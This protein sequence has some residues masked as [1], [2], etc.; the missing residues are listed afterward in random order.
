MFTKKIGSICSFVILVALF[1]GAVNFTG[2]VY[3][4]DQTSIRLDPSYVA[5][6]VGSIT[7]LLI[8][9]TGGNNLTAYDLSLSYD[10]TILQLQSWTNGSYFSNLA[11]IKSE[12]QPGMLRI[13][14]AQVGSPAVSGDG[15]IL[16]LVF[17]GNGAGLSAINIEKMDLVNAE[18]Q[19]INADLS[20]G[21]IEVYTP[22]TATLEP[23]PTSPST[24]TIQPTKTSTP[25]KTSTSTHVFSATV[26]GTFTPTR[27][28]APLILQSTSTQTQILLS[29]TV[30][31][32]VTF[33]TLTPFPSST[34]QTTR[35]VIV[36]TASD[37]SKSDPIEDD[38]T[39]Q[40][41]INTFLWVVGILLMAILIVMI[42]YSVRKK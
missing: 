38:L 41:S 40:A 19:L 31:G 22:P 21:E 39:G 4:Q 2:D 7:T 13:A 6:P 3:A 1:T 34:L 20:N 25:V 24:K 32:G 9:I 36:K 28:Q 30:T 42:I 11:L 18:G 23:L 33:P 12:N 37:Q 16:N 27:T 35:Q 5:L 15:V 8:Q 29:K 17:L 26:E 14:A 10:P